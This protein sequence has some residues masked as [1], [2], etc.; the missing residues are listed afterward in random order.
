MR[1]NAYAKEI[2]AVRQRTHVVVVVVNG[3][4]MRVGSPGFVD[5]E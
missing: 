4:A 5:G 3:D 2:V 1:I